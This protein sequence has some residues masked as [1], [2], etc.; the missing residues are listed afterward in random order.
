MERLDCKILGTL[1]IKGIGIP[2]K[3][4]ETYTQ[5]VQ[6]ACKAFQ[7]FLEQQDSTGFM[8]AD[9]RTTQLNDQV[10]HSIFTQKYRAKGDPFNRILE[11]PTFGVSNN[12]VGLQLTDVLCSAL[13][14]PMA[15]SAYCFGYVTGVHVNGRDLDIRRRYAKR[16]KLLQVRVE[17]YW[18][19]SVFD[20]HAR[21]PS[22][23]LF[24]SPPVVR[25]DKREVNRGAVPGAALV[26]GDIE[27][28]LALVLTASGPERNVPQDPMPT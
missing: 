18:S 21:R 16:L 8:V 26:Q 28:I 11:L 15:S 27:K 14:F 10:A 6:Q 19:I 5:S 1:W 22:S 9:F 23:N 17:Q 4:R 24:V 25:K 3:A 2:F 7:S 12:H 13:L 20:N